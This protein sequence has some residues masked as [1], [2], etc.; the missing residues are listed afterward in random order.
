MRLLVLFFVLV[1]GSSALA[2]T[3][4]DRDINRMRVQHEQNRT[5]QKSAKSKRLPR[6]DKPASKRIIRANLAPSKTCVLRPE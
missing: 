4:T 6:V 5:Y 3:I 1:V 2:Q